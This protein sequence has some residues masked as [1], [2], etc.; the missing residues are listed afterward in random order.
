MNALPGMVFVIRL[1][2]LEIITSNAAGAAMYR[3]NR[4][5][6]LQL[7]ARAVA[8]R[9]AED[10][11]VLELGEAAQGY[12]LIVLRLA[13][14]TPEAQVLRAAA[15]WRLTR[16]QTEVLGLL[17]CGACNKEIGIALGCSAKTVEKH[18][19]AVLSKTGSRSRPLLLLRVLK[20][21]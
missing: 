13:K 10:A 11:L 1:R 9:D 14:H 19:S 20:L 21:D 6:T 2:P 17:S 8:A 15:L 3:S 7:L 12:A 16:R 18:V 4:C 5:A